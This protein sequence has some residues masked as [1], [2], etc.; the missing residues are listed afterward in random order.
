MAQKRRQV[1]I[2]NRI[3]TENEINLILD[4]HKEVEIYMRGNDIIEE[5]TPI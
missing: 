3:P 4:Q 1:R 2:L 5:V